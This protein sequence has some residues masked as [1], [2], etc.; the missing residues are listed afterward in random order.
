MGIL[1]HVRAAGAALPLQKMDV[2]EFGEEHVVYWKPV[3]LK[4]RAEL[5]GSGDFTIEKCAL[6]VFKKGLN[7]KGERLYDVEDKQTMLGTPG[8]DR[9]VIRIAMAMMTTP[10]MEQVEKN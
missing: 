3:T 5:I 10:A 8:I 6:I 7:E 1:N 2:P 4:E 9:V